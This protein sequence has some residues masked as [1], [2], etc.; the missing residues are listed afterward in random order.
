MI[1]LVLFSTHLKKIRQIGSSSQAG[2]NKLFKKWNA[3]TLVVWCMIFALSP[4]IMEVENHPK[5]KETHIGP[6]F[7]WTVII[8]RKGI[9]SWNLAIRC[10]ENI[11]I[12]CFPSHPAAIP[13]K[14]LIGMSISASLPSVLRETSSH[15][16]SN[17]LRIHLEASIC[18]SDLLFLG[19]VNDYNSQLRVLMTRKKSQP[20][21]YTTLSKMR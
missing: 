12:R 21:M 20:R 1:C 8:G 14:L 10:L 5:W 3:T 17:T 16:F 7:H 2:V 6:I 4:I 9:G 18:G 11:A 19:R 15:N 13:T